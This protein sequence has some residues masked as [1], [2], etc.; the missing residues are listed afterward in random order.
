M[1]SFRRAFG[2]KT[3]SKPLEDG[4][5]AVEITRI[6]GLRDHDNTRTSARLDHDQSLAR[7]HPG[8]PRGRG[9]GWSRI[10]WRFAPRGSCTRVQGVRS[11]IR[12]AQRADDGLDQALR[13]LELEHHPS[14]VDC[15]H[16]A[17]VAASVECRAHRPTTLFP[18]PNEID[19]DN[20]I[21]EFA[22]PRADRAVS[23]PG[24]PG[25]PQR[26]SLRVGVVDPA[27]AIPLLAAE[28]NGYLGQEAL[29]T[30]SSWRS[31]RAVRFCRRSSRAEIDVA[32]L[33][34]CGGGRES[35]LSGGDGVAI[36]A[37]GPA[38]EDRSVALLV[39]E[40]NF[41]SSRPD[42][43]ERIQG[44][45]RRGLAWA[46]QLDGKDLAELA[47]HMGLDP[48]A[49]AAAGLADGGLIARPQAPPCWRLWPG[50]TLRRPWT[51]IAGSTWGRV[52]A[53]PTLDGLD[54]LKDLDVSTVASVVD[55]RG[56][57]SQ[58][59]PTRWAGAQAVGYALH[60]DTRRRQPDRPPCAGSRRS[61]RHSR[62]FNDRPRRARSIGDL[63]GEIARR[64][65]IA[66]LW[67]TEGCATSMAYG[68]WGYPCGVALFRRRPRP[69]RPSAP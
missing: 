12:L 69:K 45:A 17:Q 18:E 26:T 37:F 2:R 6:P 22:E 57:L 54:G 65:G 19:M 52:S 35:T 29:E 15:R 14:F 49:L 40:A 11:R 68:D 25:E 8:S 55:G 32:F 39:A 1:S 43:C 28:A 24:A 53:D 38:G 63:I 21:R 58:R 33:D 42:M 66:E 27:Q 47:D 46:A 60:R 9:N 7:E 5:D 50:A 41:R 51:L 59:H 62:D 10:R 16:S 31:S 3:G 4:P 20:T 34:G 48:A 61:G 56:V 13:L 23:E 44:T 64:R 67:L 30:R 36:A